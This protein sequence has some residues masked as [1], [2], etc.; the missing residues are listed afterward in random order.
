MVTLR[1]RPGAGL[2]ARRPR[3]TSGPGF[4]SLGLALDLRDELEAEVTGAGLDVEVDGRGRRRRAPR[5][6]ATSWCARCGPPSTAMG[7]QPPGL[8]L[9]CTQRHPARPRPGLVLGRDRRRA[10]RWPG[11]WS[12]AARCCSTTTRRFRLAADI[13]GH[14]DNVAPALLRRLRDL[15]PRR[16]RGSTPC[17]R[18]STRGSAAVVFVPPDPVSTEVA[19][20]LLPADG[21]AR[22]R[23]RRTPGARRCWSPRSAGAPE[24]LLA[25]HPRLPAPGLPRAGDAASRW[26]W[27]TSCAPTASPRSSPAPGRRCWR[28]PTPDRSARRC[29][30][31]RARR[32][33][34][35]R[36]SASTA[37]ASGRLTPRPV[38]AGVTFA[39]R[40][41]YPGAAPVDLGAAPAD[42]IVA[43]CDLLLTPA[44]V[45]ARPCAPPGRPGG[46]EAHDQRPTA[47]EP[48]GTERGK[49]L[50]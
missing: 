34:R 35:A 27:S 32:A 7:A 11:P 6:V 43:G 26:P 5:R 24:Q 9:A 31:R 42:D 16:R 2:G 45:R 3:P 17:R 19:R 33:G 40:R 12:P 47:L 36:T 25:G 30:P 41:W 13:E 20:G 8:R 39:T 23:G 48:V 37:T 1:R 29:A 4:D 18:R 44:L 49:D 38:R 10:S 46:E 28:S 50:T 22:R 15:R 14:P 21:A